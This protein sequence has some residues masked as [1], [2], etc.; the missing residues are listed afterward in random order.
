MNVLAYGP[1]GQVIYGQKMLSFSQ[2]AGIEEVD[3]DPPRARIVPGSADRALIQIFCLDVS[4]LSGRLTVMGTP[5]SQPRTFEIDPAAATITQMQP[6]SP[7]T[8]GGPGGLLSPDGKRVLAKR[9]KSLAV[10]DL[11]GRV[12]RA[13]QG[14]KKD[15]GY[16]WSPNSEMLLWARGNEIMLIDLSK[17]LEVSPPRE[18][19]SAGDSDVVWS[20]DSKYLLIRTSSLSCQLNLYGESLDVIEV[21]TGK[22]MPVK[23]SHCEIMAGA[24]GWMDR[25]IAP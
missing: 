16:L 12:V 23:S 18:L 24:F 25:A 21:A 5:W 11:Q 10:T 13:I 22:R 17:E 2:P 3:F 1:D 8:C 4:R 14:T 7:S 6:D 20:P 19:G 15:A 9:G